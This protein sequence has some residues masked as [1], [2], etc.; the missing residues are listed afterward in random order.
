MEIEKGG[1]SLLAE[2]VK[3]SP[4]NAGDAGLTA[5]SLGRRGEGNGNSLQNSCLG[6]PMDRGAQ[7]ATVHRVTELNATEH[8]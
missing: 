3:Y 6:N 4:A 1:T 2:S 5:G 7:Q 8:V